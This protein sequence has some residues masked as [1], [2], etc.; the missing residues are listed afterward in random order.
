MILEIFIL[1]LGVPI[2]FLIAWLASDELVI[3]RKWFG[4]LIL[5]SFF[6]GL[7]FLWKDFRVKAFTSGFVLIVSLVSILRSWKRKSK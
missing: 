5:V 6:S 4:A 2:G 3:G 7:L 1:A